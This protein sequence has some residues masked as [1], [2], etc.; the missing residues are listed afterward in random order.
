MYNS[1]SNARNHNIILHHQFISAI[2][3]QEFC[4][5]CLANQFL[6]C[7]ASN[8]HSLAQSCKSRLHGKITAEVAVKNCISHQPYSPEEVRQTC[9]FTSFLLHSTP[10][11]PYTLSAILITRKVLLITRKAQDVVPPLHI[12]LSGSKL[13]Y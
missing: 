8:V 6:Q 2:S 4:L 5:F 10:T 13:P 12:T 9:A 3:L 11:L 7:L 1:K